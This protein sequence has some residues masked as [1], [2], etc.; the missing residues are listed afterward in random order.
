MYVTLSVNYNHAQ[1]FDNLKSDALP[2]ED[3]GNAQHYLD[4]YMPLYYQGK[5]LTVSAGFSFG[6]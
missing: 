2:S 4:K 5:N 1:G 3:V 6:F